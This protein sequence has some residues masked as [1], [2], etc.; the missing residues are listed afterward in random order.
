[1]KAPE[2]NGN[3]ERSAQ[4]KNKG[5]RGHGG[6][7]SNVGGLRKESIVSEANCSSEGWKTH[8]A[9]RRKDDS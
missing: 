7:G 5:T 1:M 2:I 3:Q 8:S 9:Q 4:G 6:L